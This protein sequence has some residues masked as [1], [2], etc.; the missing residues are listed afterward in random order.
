MMATNADDPIPETVWALLKEFER[1]PVELASVARMS[2]KGLAV[3]LDAW[4][5]LRAVVDGA[6]VQLQGEVN[7][8]ELFREDGAASSRDWQVARFGVS[9]ATA[10]TYDQVADKAMDLPELTR[11]LGTG[12]IG[13]DK[14]RLA[15]AVAT[16]ETDREWAD[17][18]RRCTVHE[19]GQLLRTRQRP[20]EKNDQDAFEGRSLR[21]NDPCRTMTVRLP[22]EDYAATKACIQAQ[23]KAIPS[24]GEIAW[25]QRCCDAFLGLI[26][27]AGGVGGPA[28]ARTATP[29]GQGTQEQQDEARAWSDRTGGGVPPFSPY[30]AVLHAPLPDLIDP[31]GT[32][33]NVAGDLEQGGLLSLETV[34]RLLCDCTF[35][36]RGGRRFRTHDVRGA[37]TS[38]PH[39]GPA[40]GDL[41]AGSMLSVPRLS[42]QNLH[43]TASPQLVDQRRDHGPAEPRLALQLPSQSRPSQ[44]MDG[45]WERER[46]TD[47]CRAERAGDDVAPFIGV[48]RHDGS[49]GES[50]GG[51]PS[52]RLR[53][54]QRRSLA[55]VATGQ[56]SVG[57]KDAKDGSGIGG[58][59]GHARSGSPRRTARSTLG[60]WLVERAAD[61][62]DG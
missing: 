18:A 44:R 38:W 53:W 62:R 16:P 9:N 10:R 49:G 59:R 4:H 17:T 58:L 34:R 7:R 40:A 60:R 27:S 15:A 46:R 29:P 36:D 32:P 37:D 61:L 24:D 51:P 13:L 12:E 19:L 33:T 8:R 1:S 42:E 25:D 39:R 21:F 30:F 54:P 52:G 50:H 31:K 20:T 6:I 45:A 56:R 28:R 14:M 48:D 35:V 57:P 26:R 2:A 43:P 11:A 22:A 41:A 55:W 47:I 3:N 23:A 5:R